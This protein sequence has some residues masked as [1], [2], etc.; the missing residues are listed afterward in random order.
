MHGDKITYF[1]GRAQGAVY[2]H[3]NRPRELDETN[4][5][6]GCLHNVLA[7]EILLGVR[8]GKEGT[9]TQEESTDGLEKKIFAG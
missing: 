2:Q 6:Q 4:Q 9:W 7:V 1:I 8:G 5:S 3:P